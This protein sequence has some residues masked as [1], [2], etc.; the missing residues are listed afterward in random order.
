ML[1]SG[2]VDPILQMTPQDKMKIEALA[3]QEAVKEA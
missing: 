1:L 3:R 2:S